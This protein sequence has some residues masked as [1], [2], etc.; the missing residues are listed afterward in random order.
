MEQVIREE[1]LPQVRARE[2]VRGRRDDTARFCAVPTALLLLFIVIPLVALIWRA[3]GGPGFLAQ[4]DQTG[5]IG[6]ALGDVDHEC[7]H[8][9]GV[10]RRGNPSGVS[11]G[12]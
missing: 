3:I 4:H 6:G 9:A 7:G 10:T 5:R 2:R 12:A 11:P 1:S 8:T